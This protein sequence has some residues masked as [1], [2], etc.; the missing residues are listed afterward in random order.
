MLIACHITDNLNSKVGT[1]ACTI[2]RDDFLNTVVFLRVARS[3][4]DLD[5]S[6]AETFLW[7]LGQKLE[8]TTY[9]DLYTLINAFDIIV[10]HYRFAIL[11]ITL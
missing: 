4:L 10:K 5:S 11:Y 6:Y 3:E 2:R 9:Y 7:C 8:N 1:S